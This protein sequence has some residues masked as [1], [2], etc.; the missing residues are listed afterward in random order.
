MLPPG[1]FSSKLNAEYATKLFNAIFKYTHTYFK[2]VLY[3]CRKRI[4]VMTGSLFAA[5]T[6]GLCGK[7]NNLS[8]KIV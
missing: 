2:E 6:V 4:Y 3:I 1:F 5:Y 7:M 8:L